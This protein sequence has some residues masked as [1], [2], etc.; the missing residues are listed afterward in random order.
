M[1]SHDKFCRSAKCSV[2]NKL[3]VETVNKKRARKDSFLQ[4]DHE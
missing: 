1:S 4:N 2:N 3:F